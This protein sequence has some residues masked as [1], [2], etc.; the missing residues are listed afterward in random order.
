M[1]S[2]RG[3]DRVTQWSLTVRL[4]Y[5]TKIAERPQPSPRGINAKFDR[6]AIHNSFIFPVR[7]TK[8]ALG[9]R[10]AT[11]TATCSRIASQIATGRGKRAKRE[12]IFDSYTDRRVTSFLV[13][14]RCQE[15]L[16]SPLTHDI[17]HRRFIFFPLFML[18]RDIPLSLTPSLPPTH[19]VSLSLS[20]TRVRIIRY[21]FLHLYLVK[22]I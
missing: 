20:R 1:P 2:S 12:F 17:L 10:M 22:E 16:R 6:S 3:R 11:A 13:L 5:R 18:I 21:V 9:N 8:Y 4:D 14:F 7:R 19:F 15:I